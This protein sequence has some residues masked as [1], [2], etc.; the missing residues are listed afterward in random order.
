MRGQRPTILPPEVSV[1]KSGNR[2][3]LKGSINVMTKGPK[4][5]SRI[6]VQSLNKEKRSRD[7]KGCT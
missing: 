6:T 3:N 5:S 7:I 4:L 2:Q 1:V